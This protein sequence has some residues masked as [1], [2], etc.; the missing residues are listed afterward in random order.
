[1]HGHPWRWLRHL[2]HITVR[3]AHLPDDV[4]GYAEFET[5]T[6]VLDKSLTQAERRTT[7]WHEVTHLL[8]GKVP[9][10]LAGREERAVEA[11][12]AGDLI[13]FEALVTAMLWS[14]DDHEIAEELTVDVALVR[15]RLAGL[16]AGESARLNAALDRGELL[17]P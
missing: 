7:C 10:H 2:P 6:V 9:D 11:K 3:W 15:V 8:R 12:V 17:L 14:L 5:D 1:M 4:M 16:T 13:P